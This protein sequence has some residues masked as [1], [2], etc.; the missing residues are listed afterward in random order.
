MKKI[1]FVSLHV[2]KAC[3]QTRVFGDEI[4]TD[5]RYSTILMTSMTPFVSGWTKIEVLLQQLYDIDVDTEDPD[6]DPADDPGGDAQ[7]SV[8]AFLSDCVVIM[9]PVSTSRTWIMT[10]HITRTGMRLTG[11]SL[12]LSDYV[13]K[14]RQRLLWWSG[15]WPG[16]GF[17]RARSQ[18]SH[19]NI[20]LR[21]AEHTRTR[22]RQVL[23]T[24]LRA[25]LRYAV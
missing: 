7:R 5:W 1:N 20:H 17:R 3:I 19:V 22:W 21:S 2:K 18:Q 13:I 14:W 11:P 15:I 24:H 16:S 12:C 10:L 6:Y 25:C 8:N 4:W 23:K 9:T